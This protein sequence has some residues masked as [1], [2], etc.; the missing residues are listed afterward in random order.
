[1]VLADSVKK[2]NPNIKFL[3]CLLEREIHPAAANYENFDYVVLGKDLGFDNFDHFIFKH[4]IV[5]ASTSV[6]GQ[7]FRYLLSNYTDENKFVYLDPDIL[8]VSD[9]VELGRAMD[10]HGIVLTPHLTLPESKGSVAATID[11]VMDNE[12]CALQHGV[13]NLG[14]LALTRSPQGHAFA[15]W[16]ASRLNMFCHD[17]IPRGIFTDQ[18]WVDLAPCFFDVFVL[19]HPGYNVAPWNL[20]MRKITLENGN[21]FVNNEPLR[22]F[23]FSGFDSGDNEAMI[24]KY[25]PDLNDPIYELRNNYVQMLIDRGQETIGKAPWSYDC[26]FSGEKIQ[27][28]SRLVFRVN[29]DMQNKY[30]Q[31][32]AETNAKFNALKNRKQIL[33]SMKTAIKQVIKKVK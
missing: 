19:K 17:D 15:D 25:V 33:R 8:V 31:P 28:D 29:D 9:L 4:S 2:V 23:H 7:L 12:L 32:F 1:M 13:F 26:F 21:Y 14:F 30:Q 5:E 11:A 18:K 6:K 3:T 22:F 16:W 10:D 27:R 24:N 20:S